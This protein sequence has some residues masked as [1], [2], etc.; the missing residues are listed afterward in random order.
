LQGRPLG[1]GFEPA[2]L[3]VE[4]LQGLHLFPSLALSTADFMTRMVSS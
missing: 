2:R 3:V 1:S 4:P